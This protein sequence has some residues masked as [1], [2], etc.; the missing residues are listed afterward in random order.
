MLDLS[1]IMEYL[2]NSISSKRY[3]H[4]INVSKTAK[5]LAEL[6]E[7]DSAKAE[8]AGLVHDC[9]RDLEKSLQLKYLKEEGIEADE[10]TM[11]IKEL[12]H[13]PAA[14]HICKSVFAIEDEEILSA[15][16]YHT[17]GKENMS[18]LEKIIYLSDFIEPERSFPGVEELRS[19]ALKSLDEALLGAF[20][21]SISYILSTNRFVHIDTILARN[22]VLKEV[23]EHEKRCRDNSR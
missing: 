3:V 7:A 9:A 10:L 8:I 16:R 21:S 14:V 6:Y 18:L 12:L 17:T 19:I 11:N 22:Y 23:Q 1:S 5:K 20:N 2:D 15:V 13:G 4:S